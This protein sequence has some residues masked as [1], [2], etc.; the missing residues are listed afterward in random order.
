MLIS[1]ILALAAS[2]ST[3][4]AQYKGFNYGSTNTDG[5]N[6]LNHGG[7]T[8]AR[9]YTTVQAGT[10]NTP[11]SAIQAA[12]NTQT[13]LL[14]G[15]WASA[16]QANMDNEIAAL[17]AAV[18]QYGS[19]FTDLIA[20]ISVGSEDLYRISPTGVINLSG[21]GADPD[22]LVNYINQVRALNLNKPIG[23]VDT[24][25]AWVNGSN[26]A[27]IAACDFL[28]MD[29]YPYFQNT[30]DNRIENAEQ[31]FIESYNATVAAAAGK[32][33][34]VT[35]TGWPVSGPNQ[36]NAVAN[37]ENAKTYWDEIGCGFLFSQENTWWYT[38]QDAFPTTP[39]PSFGIVG[40]ELST[41]PLFDVQ[42][43]A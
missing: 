22:V 32:E 31:L 28:G 33:V 11:I 9:L 17:N 1:N 42:C 19:A 41:T 38:F 40:T 15:L 3:V 16:G 7:F 18:A 5:S 2:V 12:I 6:L 29:G 35:E 36:A 25:T 24:W 43:P 23:H 34:W 14:L 37:L 27:V 39:S 10:A 20:G 26:A 4:A 8:S 21:P 13:T 30:Q